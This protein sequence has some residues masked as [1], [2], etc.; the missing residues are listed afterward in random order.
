VWPGLARHQSFVGG[1]LSTGAWHPSVA[2]DA[3]LSTA[4][5][6]Q[7]EGGNGLLRR[8]KKDRSQYNVCH[9]RELQ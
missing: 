3:T 5:C 1:D 6:L 9:I 2:L 8:S 7:R 4:A